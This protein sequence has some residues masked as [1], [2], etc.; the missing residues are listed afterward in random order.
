MTLTARLTLVAVTALVAA[1]FGAL[2]CSDS[3]TPAVSGSGTGGAAT[4]PKGGATST[5][6]ATTVTGTGGATTTTS[7]SGGATEAT[8]GATT[9]AAAGAPATGACD[10][11]TDKPPPPASGTECVAGEAKGGTC[12]TEGFVCVKSCGP[13]NSGW[14]TETCTTQ[15][16]G[17]LKYAEVSAC[18]W[19]RTDYSMWKIP[20]TMDATC[21]A[22]PQ[23]STDCTVSGCTV[24]GPNY[25][26]STSTSKAGYCI[27]VPSANAAAG[28]TGKWSCG[29]ATTAWPCPASAGCS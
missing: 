14:K 3:N 5:G 23:A 6:G 28:V 18:V 29:T 7:A 15:T 17:T 1:G 16:D 20:A 12:T 26:D 8:G 24:C 4:T 19:T 2:A 22:A 11:P 21:P 9:T 27:C 13:T 25:L 10:Y